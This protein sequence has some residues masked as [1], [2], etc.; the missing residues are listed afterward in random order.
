[1]TLLPLIWLF[2]LTPVGGELSGNILISSDALGYDLQYR[3]YLPAGADSTDALPALYVFDGQWYIDEGR[4]HETL[5]SLIERSRIEPVIVVFVDNR[6]PENLRLNR[7][8]GQFFCNPRYIRF[9]TDELVPAVDAA[10][11]TR[12]AADARSVLG[13]SFGGLAAAC[14]GLHAHD[15]FSGIA[16]QSPAM[17]PVPS[18]WDAW[19]DSSRLPVRIFLSSGDYNDNEA[20]TRRLRDIL[21]KKRYE[22]QYVEVPFAHNWMNW[23]PLLD[24]VLLFLYGD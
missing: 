1:M 11:P 15:T 10:W 22:M 4:M 21:S 5:D 18:M 16:M 12:A 3:V 14:F 9:F 7:R 8:N 17:H 13:L 2:A 6:A 24:D 20:R 19:A 23:R